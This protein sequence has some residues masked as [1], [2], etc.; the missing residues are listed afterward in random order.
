MTFTRSIRLDRIKD[1]ETREQFR[2]LEENSLSNVIQ[3]DAAPTADVPLL[4]D[5]TIGEFE[6]VLYWRV[7]N[8]IL[9]LTPS[10]TITLT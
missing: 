10:S 5:T 7:R 1:E 9:V 6:S 3:L 8:K 4:E 2:E